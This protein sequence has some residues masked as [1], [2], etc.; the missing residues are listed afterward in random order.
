MLASSML[1]IQSFNPSI[2]F[3]H[4]VHSL[5][6]N[7][8]HCILHHSL[9]IYQ[10]SV[11]FRMVPCTKIRRLWS[12]QQSLHIL[13]SRILSVLT[14]TWLLFAILVPGVRLGGH[15]WEF[16]RICRVLFLNNLCVLESGCS[17][18][19]SPAQTAYRSIN[20]KYTLKGRRPVTPSWRPSRRVR[21]R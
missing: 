19:R 10:V 9:P 13:T 18:M 2:V 4:W 7:F 14:I 8:C 11:L 5:S 3:H 17:N 15:W 20:Q 1:E 21:N 6:F 16:I 12:K